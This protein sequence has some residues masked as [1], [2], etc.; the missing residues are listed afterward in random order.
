MMPS[1]WHDWHDFYMLLGTASA[2]LVALLFVA[3]SIGASFLTPE[4]SVATRTFMSPVVFHFSTLLL[5]SLIAIVP[6]HTA[7]SLAIGITLVAVAGLAYTTVVLVGLARA[8]VSD[9]ADRFG[10]GFCPLAA[11]LAMLAAAGLVISRAALAADILGVALL[12]LLAVSI[13][14]AWDLMLAFA[15]Q[16][17]TKSSDT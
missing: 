5:I 4:R 14:N 8:S 15:R 3:V 2:A 11:Y 16:V 10:Y 12:L 17:A 1:E 13:R 7:L 9:I 6:S